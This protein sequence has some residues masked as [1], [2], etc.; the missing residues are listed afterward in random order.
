[1]NS[2]NADAQCVLN[3]YSLASAGKLLGIIHIQRHVTKIFKLLIC[4]GFLHPFVPWAVCC[5]G[6]GSCVRGPMWLTTLSCYPQVICA[7]RPAS[8]FFISFDSMV[9][10]SE[11]SSLEFKVKFLIVVKIINGKNNNIVKAIYCQISLHDK[12]D[13]RNIIRTGKINSAVDSPNQ[14]ILNAFPLLL[15]KYLE[16]VVLEVCDISP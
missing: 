11:D 16:I 1:M 7:D 15:L 2:S 5:L 9:L 8:Q 13:K 6:V 14:A 10:S 4:V 12:N 3:S